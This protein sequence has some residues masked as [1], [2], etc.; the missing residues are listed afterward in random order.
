MYRGNITF[1]VLLIVTI[2]MLASGGRACTSLQKN[3]RLH[4]NLSLQFRADAFSMDN[5]PTFAPPNTVFGSLTFG[6]VS[7][8]QNQPT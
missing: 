5:T 2:L 6:V 1:P 7:A 3:A 8:M 4:E